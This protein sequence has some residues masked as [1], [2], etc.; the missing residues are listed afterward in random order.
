[1]R[2]I[3]AMLAVGLFALS[4]FAGCVGNTG[5]TSVG[6]TEAGE[7]AWMEGE[8]ETTNETSGNVTTPPTQDLGQN[9]TAELDGSVLLDGSGLESIFLGAGS[10]IYQ[11][12]GYITP[13]SQPTQMEIVVTYTSAVGDCKLTIWVPG[14]MEADLVGTTISSENDGGGVET[15]LLK[16]KDLKKIDAA[17]DWQFTVYTGAANCGGPTASL[18]FHLKVTCWSAPVEARFSSSA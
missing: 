16:P 14:S 17:G 7:S 2:K 18:D 6:G 12:Q 13:S 10:L 4:A 8:N 9:Y 11:N 15:I 5:E 1:M 3:L